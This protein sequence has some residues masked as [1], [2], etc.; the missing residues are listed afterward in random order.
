MKRKLNIDIV[1]SIRK[2]QIITKGLIKTKGIGSYKSVF[3]GKGLDFSDYRT[4]D[5]ND[6][7]SLIDWKASK[8]SNELLIRQYEEERDLNIFFVI[9]CGSGMV[10]GSTEKLKN[11]YAAEIVI[12]LAFTILDA[13][14]SVGLIMFNDKIV[15]KVYPGKGKGQFYS[16]VKALSDPENYGGG[17]SFDNV[18]D[19]ILNYLKQSTVVILVSDFVGM[20]E[21]SLDKFRLISTKY[22]TIGIMVRDPRDKTLPTDVGQIVIEDPYSSKS[23]LIEPNLIKEVYEEEIKKQEKWIRDS[24]MRNKS[25]FLSLT[26]DKSFVKPL[27][28]LFNERA[29]KW[30]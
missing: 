12:S 8:R 23:L 10:F 19:F 2:L 3:R 16:V 1:P 13:G 20:N 17:F 28:G 29:L 7:A 27:I 22:D 18:T 5:R 30:K 15:K 4:Y 25:D 9:D 24:F 14:D 21:N 6:D 11:E 26:T